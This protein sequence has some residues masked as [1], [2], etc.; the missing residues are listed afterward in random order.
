LLNVLDWEWGVGLGRWGLRWR[1]L[2][3]LEDNILG[4]GECAALKALVDELLDFGFSDLNG[5]V[6]IA[7]FIM[8]WN[9]IGNPL[10]IS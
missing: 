9:W 4:V 5:H 1:G 8:P 10:D 7:F 2:E 3:G 6:A